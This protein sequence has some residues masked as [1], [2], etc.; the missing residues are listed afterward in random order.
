[1][2]PLALAETAAK[3]LGWPLHVIAESGHVP[4]LERPAAFQRAL[5]NALEPST[6]RM[7]F[8]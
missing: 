3:R 2:V 7:T 5:R 8:A 6:E 4:H 1:M